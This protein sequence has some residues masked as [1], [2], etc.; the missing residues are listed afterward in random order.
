MKKAVIK[1]LNGEIQEIIDLDA[2]L[3]QAEGFKEYKPVG[4]IPIIGKYPADKYWAD[5]FNKLKAI[6][7]ETTTMPTK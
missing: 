4:P 7:D 2:A 5:I 3:S 6:K 1:D